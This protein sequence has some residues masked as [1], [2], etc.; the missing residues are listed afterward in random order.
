MFFISFGDGYSQ[1]DV[2]R[3]SVVDYVWLILRKFFF[4]A[5]FRVVAYIN[6]SVVN[7]PKK[8][9]EICEKEK[10]IQKKVILF[11]CYKKIKQFYFIVRLVMGSAKR[12]SVRFRWIYEIKTWKN[13]WFLS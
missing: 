1:A 12:D 13:Q 5:V 7:V 4:K 2:K 6:V 11:C 3:E 10:K 9:Y 8:N